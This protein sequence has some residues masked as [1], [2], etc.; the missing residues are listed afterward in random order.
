M[1]PIPWTVSV[2]DHPGSSADDIAKE[3][4]WD[5][6]HEHRI[7]FKNKQDRVPGIIHQHDDYD[8]KIEEARQDFRVWI[9]QTQQ[10]KL[11]DFRDVM[12]NQKVGSDESCS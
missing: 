9:M 8:E 6:G 4:D 11:I 5:A 3:P 1:P 10:G 12:K 2:R 7:G